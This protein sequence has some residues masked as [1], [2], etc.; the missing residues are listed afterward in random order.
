MIIFNKD[1]YVYHHWHT[2]MLMWLFIL[3]PLVFNL[4]FKRLF[5]HV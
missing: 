3:V 1:D 5:E 2:A 4:Y